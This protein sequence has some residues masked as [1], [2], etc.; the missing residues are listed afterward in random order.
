MIA[1][2]TYFDFDI[3]GD[4]R[5]AALTLAKDDVSH[6]KGK[7]KEGKK[8]PIIDIY[9]IAADTWNCLSLLLFAYHMHLGR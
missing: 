8:M 5:N 2:D 4:K 6:K 9:S 7:E 3:L 1:Y